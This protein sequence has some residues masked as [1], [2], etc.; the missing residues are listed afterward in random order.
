MKDSNGCLTKSGSYPTTSVNRRLLRRLSHEVRG[1][2][3]FLGFPIR[4][5][6]QLGP[7]HEMTVQMQ[8]KKDARS[9]RTSCQGD[10]HVVSTL[11]R[12]DGRVEWNERVEERNIVEG[13]DL[14]RSDHRTESI[15]RVDR[16]GMTG[17]VGNLA[18]VDGVDVS[19]PLAALASR[20]SLVREDVLREDRR[21]GA[22]G[23]GA[24][25]SLD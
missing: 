3:A 20:L 10:Y 8:T 2:I 25:R 12:V 17:G 15:A 13:D 7:I 11:S 6:I 18:I 5:D 24:R 19:V 21:G 16:A 4:H 9:A 14:L 23:S 1:S 22:G